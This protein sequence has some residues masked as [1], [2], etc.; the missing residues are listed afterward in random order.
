MHFEPHAATE[1]EYYSGSEGEPQHDDVVDDAEVWMD[2]HSE[3]LLTLWHQAQDTV[4]GLGVYV[5][6]ACTFN[7]FCHF[8]YAKSSGRKPPC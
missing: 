7:D 3:Q 6:D 1:E 8:C 5:L 2:Y 4:A